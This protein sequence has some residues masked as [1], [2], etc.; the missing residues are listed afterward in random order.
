MTTE[1]AAKIAE[2]MPRAKQDL[3][4]LVAVPSI[5]DPRQYPPEEC[6]KAA[7]WVADAFSDAGLRDLRRPERPPSHPSRAPP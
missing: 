3:T 7:R 2:L 6:H 1:L 5:A 4:D